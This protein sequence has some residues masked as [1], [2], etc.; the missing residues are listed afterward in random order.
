[1]RYFDI[2]FS[3]EEVRRLYR[4]YRGERYLRARRQLEPN[5]DESASAGDLESRRYELD[6]FLRQH[7]QFEVAGP[8]LDYGGGDGALIPPIFTGRRYVHD[9]SNTSL[10]Q[11][12]ERISDI[13]RLGE[14]PSFVLLSHVLEHL[15]EPLDQ[16]RTIASV[17]APEG[18]LYVEVPNERYRLRWLGPPTLYRRCFNLVAETRLVSPLVSFA[19]LRLAGRPAAV[20]PL[21]EKGSSSGDP[22]EPSYWS[23]EDLRLHEHINFF[24]PSALHRI[25]ERAD[26]SVTAFDSDDL[27]YRLLAKKVPKRHSA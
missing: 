22:S 5:Y 10:A 6:R 3:E 25:L 17:L 16:L 13:R 7:L 15:S 8:I 4:D 9:I 2:R 26:F 27:K 11:R 20:L 21:A 18:M 14:A 1:L 12:A 19:I 23:F 24:S